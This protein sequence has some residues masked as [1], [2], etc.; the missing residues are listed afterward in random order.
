VSS[1]FLENSCTIA[2]G[3]FKVRVIIAMYEAVFLGKKYSVPEIGGMVLFFRDVCVS[4]FPAAA[5]LEAD[6]RR[7]RACHRRYSINAASLI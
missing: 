4:M 6:R 1:R 5:S 7:A 2:L 3:V